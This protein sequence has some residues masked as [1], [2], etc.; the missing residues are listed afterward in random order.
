MYKPMIGSIIR[1]YFIAST[2]SAFITSPL[3][4]NLSS[5]LR[6]SYVSKTIY[7]A[8]IPWGTNEQG[9]RDLGT[10]YGEVSSVRLPLDVEGRVRGFGFIEYDNEESA[11]KAIENINGYEL[12]GRQLRAA[13]ASNSRDNG[14]FGRGRFGRGRVGRAGGFSGGYG[15]GF[16][17]RDNSNSEW[18]D[19]RRTQ[20]G[21]EQ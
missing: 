15:R 8:N 2:R 14:G 13:E 5:I 17:S 20:F 10:K 3:S 18:E 12:D 4:T 21:D 9:L 19:R 7:V 1:S 11:Q 16:G 6:R